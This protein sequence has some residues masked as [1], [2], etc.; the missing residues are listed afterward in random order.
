MSIPDSPR[1]SPRILFLTADKYPAHRVDTVILFAKELVGRLG[2]NVGWIMQS[3]E[4]R[5]RPARILWDD[6]PVWLAA[7]DTR[8][9][10]F[11]RL[12]KRFQNWRNDLRALR[13]A[14]L[15]EYDLVQARDRYLGGLIGLIAA[16][17]ANKPYVFW[18]SFPEPEASVYRA[19]M[20]MARYPLI[21][22]IRGKLQGL[23][24]YRVLLRFA[25]H[26]FV[27]SEQMKLDV[28]KCGI[29]P[30]KLT[31]V[32]MGVDLESFS[33]DQT[34]EPKSEFDPG[35]IGYL[36][37]LASERRI[38]F[39][40]RVLALVHESNPNVRLLL[41][42]SGDRP[43]DEENILNE[44]RRLGI[45]SKLD[46]TGQLP[47]KEALARISR[48]QI[49][50][51]P[52][53]PTPILNSTSPTKLVEYMALGKPVVVNDHP[54]QRLVIEESAAGICVPYDESAF[55]GAIIKLLESPEQ[56]AEMGKRG[57]EYVVNVRSYTQIAKRLDS[58]YREILAR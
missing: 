49:C 29:N 43:G 19:K 13:I 58:K 54:E 18:L 1:K 55:S 22:W 57:F 32:P 12:R 20:G 37:T 47:Q 38:D 42:G 46:M 41:I 34:C 9:G 11:P 27:Q 17:R 25:D 33:L 50:L 5:R 16:K 36:G 40:V 30:A 45:E 35:T 28:S 6:C 44:A 26:A 10:F 24:L 21:Y 23:L 8:E 15:D 56:C 51:S 4:L 53:Y 7:A 14:K 2:Y 31:A 39:L 48:S 3:V 52:F